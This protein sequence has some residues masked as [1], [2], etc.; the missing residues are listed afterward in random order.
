MK[1]LFIIDGAMGTSK[2]DLVSYVTDP[3]YGVNASVVNKYTTRKKRSNEEHKDLD[4]EIGCVVIPAVS[5]K[6]FTPFRFVRRS[7]CFTG[8]STAPALLAKDRDG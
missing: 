7:I 3:K 2:T 1:N 6:S 8:F 4:Y 5:Q